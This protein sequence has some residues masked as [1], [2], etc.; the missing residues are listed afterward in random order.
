MVAINH[1]EIGNWVR[2]IIDGGVNPNPD[3]TPSTP[4]GGGGEDREINSLSELKAFAQ[5]VRKGDECYGET[6]K[7]GAN[8][9]CNGEVISIGGQDT[10]SGAGTV[11]RA[12]YDYG[13]F[14]GEFDGQ[15]FT[16]S[17]F[18]IQD[19]WVQGAINL[20]TYSYGLF[21]YCYGTIKNLRIKDVTA[22]ISAGKKEY[23]TVGALVGYSTTVGTIENCMVDNFYVVS[24]GTVNSVYVGGLFAVGAAI[25]TNCY[26]R[27]VWVEGGCGSLAGIGC[28]YNDKDR[29]WTDYSSTITKCVVDNVSTPSGTKYD[30]LCNEVAGIKYNHVVTN[31]YK[32]QDSTY[33]NLNPSAVGG[34]DGSYPWYFYAGYNDGWPM[35][36]KFMSWQTL[37]FKCINGTVSPTSIKIP[38][39]ETPAY[40]T[41]SPTISVMGQ[42]VTAT[43]NS[44]LG[45]D[46]STSWSVS[47]T[48]HTCKF[49][50]AEYAVSFSTATNT[51]LKVNGT[52]KTT[53]QSFT[54]TSG[55]NI[56]TSYTLFSSRSGIYKTITF[57]FTDSSGTSISIVYSLSSNL[58]Y[59]SAV[60]GA[61]LSSTN[62]VSGN[63]SISVTTQKKSYNSI[64]Q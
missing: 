54:L 47:G 49:S 37:N 60:T 29:T 31:S 36:R 64:F 22:N 10:D 52:A 25:A 3:I 62:K 17:N 40:N 48:T 16:I 23:I 53:A 63:R 27:D 55:T 61:S 2:G 5:S 45:S 59:I 7:L 15:G 18:K 11:C 30:Y 56:Q 24:G 39:G 58:Y 13:S 44:S 6:W 32:A 42:T 4:D 41:S 28:V 8:I 50:V 1:P 14:Q 20:N 57:S 51:T 46:Y 43:P 38:S 21:P 34:N 12:G 33:T 26:V 9:N 19:H 35:L